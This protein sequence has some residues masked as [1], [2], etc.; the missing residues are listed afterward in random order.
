[1]EG[2]TE[3]RNDQGMM[4][5]VQHHEKKKV[6]L[7]VQHQVNEKILILVKHRQTQTPLPILMPELV[8]HEIL[9]VRQEE[10]N[11]NLFVYT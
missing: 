10:E 8:V 4:D 2:L 9:E 5:K 11:N 1:V 3:R 7:I 6:I